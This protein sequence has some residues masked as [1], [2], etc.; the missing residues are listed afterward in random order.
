VDNLQFLLGPVAEVFCYGRPLYTEVDNTTV[1]QVLLTFESGALGYLGSDWVC[2]GVFS[3]RLYG[4][5]ANLF[6]ELD[7]GWWAQSAET[8][9]HSRLIRQEFEQRGDDPEVVTF[10]ATDHLKDEIEEFARA[11]RGETR[12]EVD[13]EAARRNLAVVLAAVESARTGRPQRVQDFL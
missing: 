4:T 11:V 9:A 6:Y 13:A 3:L 10:P 5:E 12:A 7:F 2:P 1:A 8:D